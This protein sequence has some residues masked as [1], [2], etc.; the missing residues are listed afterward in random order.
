MVAV[1]LW[2]FLFAAWNNAGSERVVLLFDFWWVHRIVLIA[3]F[4]VVI[5]CFFLDCASGTQICT[6]TKLKL[7]WICL[8]SRG[9][10]GGSSKLVRVHAVLYTCQS[11]T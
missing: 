1:I 7:S 2:G 4:S 5:E 6:R 11:S 10:T 8:M 9:R 3:M